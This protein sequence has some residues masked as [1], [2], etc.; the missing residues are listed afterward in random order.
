V[1][2]TKYSYLSLEK[3]HCTYLTISC[4]AICGISCVLYITRLFILLYYLRFMQL[5]LLRTTSC[6]SI[7]YDAYNDWLFLD[8]AGKLTLPAVQEACVVVAQCYLPRTYSRVLNSNMLVTDSSTEVAIWLGMEFLPYL[9]MSGVKQ[10]ASISAS[11]LP[12]HHLVQ[13]VRQWVPELLLHF[14]TTTDDA[15]AWLQ[16]PQSSATQGYLLPQPQAATQSQLVQGMQQ[17]RQQVQQRRQKVAKQPAHAQL[18]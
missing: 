14:F 5:H 4:L 8:W 11:A 17:L 15:I 13:T 9:A 10:V 18:A 1:H 3:E 12:G 16:Q 2:R 7:Y 6:L